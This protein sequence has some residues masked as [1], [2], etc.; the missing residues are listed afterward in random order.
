MLRPCYLRIVYD[1]L[2]FVASVSVQFN[3]DVK[4]KPDK[5]AWFGYSTL[6]KAKITRLFI[7]GSWLNKG[8]ISASGKQQ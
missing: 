8:L 1:V 2:H 3:R 6:R 5:R 7:Y 4:A